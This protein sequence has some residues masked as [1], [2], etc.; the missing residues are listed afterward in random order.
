MLD[1]TPTPVRNTSCRVTAYLRGGRGPAVSAPAASACRHSSGYIDRVFR[2]IQAVGKPALGS[3]NP[4]ISTSYL[5][6]QGIHDLIQFRKYPF[7][8]KL[9]LLGDGVDIFCIRGRR[10]AGQSLWMRGAAM[11]VTWPWSSA[12]AKWSFTGYSSPS[13]M[14]T[15]ASFGMALFMSLR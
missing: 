9:W 11:Y 14:R 5:H 1:P 4:H 13:S 6:I 12:R 3:R 8:R 7:Y 2:A 15:S 10:A